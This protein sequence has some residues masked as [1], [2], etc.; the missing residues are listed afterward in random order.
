M[1]TEIPQRIGH[2]LDAEGTEVLSPAYRLQEEFD[3]IREE[4]EAETKQLTAERKKFRRPEIQE[5]I[6][7]PIHLNPSHMIEDGT[8]R[9]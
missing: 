3:R 6:S 9:R 2:V 4:Q 7:R 1:R 8:P 5:H